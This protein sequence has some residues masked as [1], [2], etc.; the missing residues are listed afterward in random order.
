MRR[1]ARGGCRRRVDGRL[2]DFECAD[3]RY[4]AGVA[5]L[6]S[7][8]ELHAPLTPGAVC[9]GAH[10]LVAR[11]RR[12]AGGGVSGDESSRLLLREAMVS[13][14]NE[15]G[16]VDVMY[17]DAPD[18]AI[19]GA[20]VGVPGGARVRGL[21]RWR[22]GRGRRRGVPNPAVARECPARP[23]RQRRGAFVCAELQPR[24]VCDTCWQQW[25][26]GRVCD[27]G[28]RRCARARMCGSVPLVEQ[29]SFPGSYRRGRERVGASGARAPR[30]AHA[31][32]RA[33]R[34]AASAADGTKGARAHVRTH[35]RSPIFTSGVFQNV[36]AR[37][38]LAVAN[39]A[40]AEEA[41]ENAALDRTARVAGNRAARG[42]PMYV[43]S[44]PCRLRSGL[45]ARCSKS[46]QAM[47][48][49][50]VAAAAVVAAAEVVVEC[51]S[52]RCTRLW[53]LQS[54]VCSHQYAQ[55]VRAHTQPQTTNRARHK[56]SGHQHLVGCAK[57]K[58]H[59]G[60][61]RAICRHAH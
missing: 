4:S 35:T 25:A 54:I 5:V 39:E 20:C 15:N 31:E 8:H 52:G 38:L 41:R 1:C 30:A 21:P 50:V 56:T 32:A 57:Q 49:V 19:G 24:P 28:T 6:P 12:A 13:L 3:R 17:E 29:S 9:A 61:A 58:K 26:G 47:P 11:A 43:T 42:A 60:R 10:V 59:A 18:G 2:G 23:V 53:I 34:L 27:R 40:C 55:H 51:V 22:C 48:A 46:P 16:T 7:L 14:D 37:K 36:D 45:R 44:G 33:R